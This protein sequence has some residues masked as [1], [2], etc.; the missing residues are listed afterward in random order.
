MLNSN[1]LVEAMVMH[2]IVHI[3]HAFTKYKDYLCWLSWQE[4][5]LCG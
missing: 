5:F 3:T 4:M 1:T 2:Y